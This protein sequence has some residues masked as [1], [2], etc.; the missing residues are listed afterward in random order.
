MRDSDQEQPYLTYLRAKNIDALCLELRKR[1]GLPGIRAN[2]K[3]A[4][5][6]GEEC[7]T[8]G[9]SIDHLLEQMLHLSPDFAPGDTDWEFVPTCAVYGFAARARKDVKFRRKVL[10]LLH[11]AADDLRFRVRDAV[12]QALASIGAL[13]GDAWV[14]ELASFTDG[15]V[16]AVAALKALAEDRFLNE[17]HDAEAVC[18]RLDEC[19]VLAR[20][21]P[22]SAERYPGMKALIDALGKTPG[23]VAIRFGTPVFEVMKT[24]CT[25]KEPMLREA[26]EKNLVGSRLEGRFRDEIR[27]VRAALEASAP[28]RRDPTTFVGKTRG[29]GKKR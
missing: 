27:G 14:R 28:V 5:A 25:V 12:P 2:L 6:F 9:P 23:L 10:P 16:Y 15:Y 18:A 19:F 1:S 26:I 20:E 4:E 11:E 8:I 29:R 22:R 13:D 24:W 7:A 21:A 17:I 3:L